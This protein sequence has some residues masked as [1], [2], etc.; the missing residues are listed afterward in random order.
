MQAIGFIYVRDVHDV[1][2]QFR[3]TMF[4]VNYLIRVI[5]MSVYNNKSEKHDTIEFEAHVE[6]LGRFVIY[7]SKSGD[8]CC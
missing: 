5:S 8:T 4:H 6:T 3:H 7:D 2:T 1:N